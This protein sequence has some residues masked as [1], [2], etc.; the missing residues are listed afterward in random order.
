MN[1]MNYDCKYLCELNQ[2]CCASAQSVLTCK[3]SLISTVSALR[4]LVLL[5]LEKKS[6]DGDDLFVPWLGS[7]SSV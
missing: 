2:L 5:L 6:H 1:T 3:S 4:G 7:W